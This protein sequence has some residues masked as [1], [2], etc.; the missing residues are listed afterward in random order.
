MYSPIECD[1]FGTFNILGF[2]NII[3]TPFFALKNYKLETT[4]YVGDAATAPTPAVTTI[5]PIPIPKVQLQPPSSLGL[6]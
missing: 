6:E 1:A 2:G 3:S 4:D 5:P